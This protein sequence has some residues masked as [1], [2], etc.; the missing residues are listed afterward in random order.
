MEW[1][2]VIQLGGVRSICCSLWVVA[3]ITEKKGAVIASERFGFSSL[4][5]GSGLG[6]MFSWRVGC[7]YVL[8]FYRKS[9][10]LEILVL[11][12]RDGR[13]DM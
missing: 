2:D 8:G 13:L 6:V 4:F 1:R 9:G 3:L 12:V 10:R 5:R 11:S 7:F